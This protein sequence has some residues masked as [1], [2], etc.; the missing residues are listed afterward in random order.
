M[1]A[2]LVSLLYTVVATCI[3]IGCM[4]ALA[5]VTYAFQLGLSMPTWLAA[6]ICMWP[7][8]GT[9]LALDRRTPV[10]AR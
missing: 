3:W 6:L 2:L 1:K 5:L 10:W 8:V 4:V 9:V 7:A